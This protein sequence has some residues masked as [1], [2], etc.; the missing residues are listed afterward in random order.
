MARSRYLIATTEQPRVR[1]AVDATRLIVGLLVVLWSWRV[2]A[3]VEDVQ[4]A[5]DGNLTWVPG[6]LTGTLSVLYGFAALYAIGLLVAVL[7]QWKERFDAVRDMVL[8]VV[9]TA[10]LASLLTRFVAGEWPLLL[11]ELGLADPISQYPIFRVAVVAAMIRAVAPHLTRP[12]RRF[13]SFVVLI[14]AAAGV[15]LGFGLIT[16]A[17]GA[18]SLGIAAAAS[19]LL[20]F[21]SPSGYPNMRSIGE[22]MSGLGVPVSDVHLNDDQ[23]WGVRRLIGESGVHGRVEIKAYG[24]DATDS[25]LF[26]RSWRYLWYRDSESTLALTRMQSVEHEA[27]VTMMAARTGA[28]VANVLA[29]GLGG[30][31][32]AILAVDR[33]GRQLSEVDPKEVAD[34]DL[35]SIWKSV[36]GLHRSSISHG[37]LNALAIS[38]EDS[39]HQIGD[40]ASG[41]LGASEAFQAFD[42]VELLFSLSQIVGVDRSVETA[43][44]GLGRQTLAAVLPYVQ[45]PAI[46]A[47]SRRRVHKPKRVIANIRE[48]IQ[49]LTGA[50]AEETIQ[51]R[52]VQVKN[53]LMTG[54]TL[55]AVYFLISALSDIDFVAVWDIVSG[56]TWALIIASFIVGQFVFF[57][58]ATAMLAAVGYPIPLKP[59][60]VLQ[61]AIKFISLAVPSAAGRIGMT[62]AFLRKYG[63]SFTASLVQ[64][65]VDTISGLIVEVFIIVMAVLFGGLNF[66]LTTGDPEWLSIIVI[67]TVIGIAVVSLVKRIER[68]RNWVMP[69]VGEA[70]GALGGVIKDPKRTLLLLGGNF[71]ARFV[72]AISMWLILQ[73][74]GVSLG[75]FSVLAATVLTG[76]LGGVIPVPGGIGVSEAILTAS[77]VIFGVD[78]TTAFAAAVVYRFVTFYIPSGYGWFSMQW[79]DKNGYI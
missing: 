27:L 54:L 49:S 10:A 18:I 4:S 5:V 8:A 50:E 12:M 71:A 76:L 64:G 15:G 7:L 69:I 37:S 33:Q 58:E 26:A 77:L 35:V 66:G 22:A 19:V 73:S 42:V 46:E 30:D 72:L 21:G 6:W 9:M 65:S 38:I 32:V 48:R 1:R 47:S 17:I 43:L 63:L 78:E 31:D 23:S 39:G 13:G 70:W 3:K 74:M 14:A 59:A 57:P 67:L 41:T 2:Y 45:L 20:I 68:L 51:I 11:P 62:A 52:R 40:F 24:R 55:F 56:A 25:Q 28:S 34:A 36:D 75:I 16:A 29:A 53:L 60:V 44:D 79:L 61:S